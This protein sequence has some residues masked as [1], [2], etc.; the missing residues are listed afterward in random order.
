LLQLTCFTSVCVPWQSTTELQHSKKHTHTHRQKH[1]QN[2]NAH[3]HAHTHTLGRL[4][5]PVRAP[6]HSP[7]PR[8][9]HACCC[10]LPTRCLLGRTPENN[11]NK[12]I[13]N[14]KKNACCCTPLTRCLLGCTPE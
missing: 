10:K 2:T 13:K 8:A 1:T 11:K 7:A 4:H 14:N 5:D 3:T 6:Q 9:L 12:K